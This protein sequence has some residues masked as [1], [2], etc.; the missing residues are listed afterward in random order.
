[1][2]P[3]SHKEPELIPSVFQL[4]WSVACVGILSLHVSALLTDWELLEAKRPVSFL[5]IVLVSQSA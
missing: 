5:C 4:P 3:P 1:M 2:L